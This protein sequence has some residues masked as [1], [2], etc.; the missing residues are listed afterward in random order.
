MTVSFDLPIEI[1]SKARAQ[2]ADVAA[3]ARQTYLVELY[4]RG[5]LTH[6]ELSQALGIDRFETDGVLKQHGAVLE[7]DAN[8]F[9]EELVDLRQLAKR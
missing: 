2:Q 6:F 9:A 1:E 4:R 7:L 5:T 8:R 3:D